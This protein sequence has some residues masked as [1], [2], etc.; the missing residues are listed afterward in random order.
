MHTRYT[1]RMYNNMYNNTESGRGS[2]STAAEH[3]CTIASTAN[4]DGVGVDSQPAP[5]DDSNKCASLALHN[6]GSKTGEQWAPTT[7]PRH[8]YC[9]C[10][11]LGCLDLCIRPRSIED[12]GKRKVKLI[13]ASGAERERTTKRDRERDPNKCRET[14]WQLTALLGMSNRGFIPS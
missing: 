9:V 11:C 6:G 10:L 14:G 1:G 12:I 13:S 8:T 2:V 5:F 7:R 4:N 3:W